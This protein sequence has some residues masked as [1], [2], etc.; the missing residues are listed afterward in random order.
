[1][2]GLTPFQ[3]VRVAHLL[4]GAWIT[5]RRASMEAWEENYRRL[6]NY[7]RKA[8]K[9]LGFE[10]VSEGTQHLPK[11]GPILFVSNHQGTL[12]P[13]PLVASCPLP[14]G[15]IS[16]KENETIPLLGRWAQ[17]IGTI[18]F[19]R[20]TRE[21]N[22]HMLRESARRLKQGKNLLIFPKGTR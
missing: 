21:G 7:S 13:A 18:H 10:L 16:K 12:D 3:V 22:V 11:Q 5:S 8:I 19:D 14:F 1:M 17:L 9:A 20:E 6:Q 4:P 15:F 2:I